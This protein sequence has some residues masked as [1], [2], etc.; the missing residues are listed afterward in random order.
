MA[1]AA[2]RYLLEGDWEVVV[3]AVNLLEILRLA[4]LLVFRSKLHFLSSILH[5]L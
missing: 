4:K 2:R 1:A 3:G 5:S